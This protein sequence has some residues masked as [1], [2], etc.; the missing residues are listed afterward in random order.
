MALVAPFIA[1]WVF[2]SGWADAGA[3]I[4]VLAPTCIAQTVVSPL[5]RGLLISGREEQKLVADIAFLLVPILT[6]YFASSHPL[7][8]AIAYFSGASVVSFLIYYVVIRRALDG[9]VNSP[10]ARR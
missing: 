3:M 8:V 5:S 7:I 10:G 4:A 6:L 9:G 1:G 2:G